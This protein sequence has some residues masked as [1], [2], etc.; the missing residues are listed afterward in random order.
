MA[1]LLLAAAVPALGPAA[2]DGSP[3]ALPSL[4]LADTTGATVSDA[5][6]A[7]SSNWVL[8]VVDADKHLTVAVLPRLQKKE[9]DWGGKLVVVATGS[10][11]AFERMVAQND[12]LAGVRWY[13]DTSG[14]LLDRLALSGTPVLLGIRPDNVIAWQLAAIPETPERAQG[15]VSSWTSRVVPEH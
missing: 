5:A 3:R 4:A 15:V 7:Q 2:A 6:L 14:Q 13:R 1:V 11:A 8:L 12:K 10:A 9:G